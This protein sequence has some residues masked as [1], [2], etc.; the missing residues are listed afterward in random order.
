MLIVAGY[1]RVAP[2]NREA[3]L[4]NRTAAVVRSR[5][6]QGCHAYAFSPD[7]IDPGLVHLYERWESAENLAAHAAANKANPNQPDGFEVLEHEVVQ[8]KIAAV[9]PLGS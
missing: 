7:V 1:F 3:F 6:E 9:G 8:Y 2:E 4:K 5:G